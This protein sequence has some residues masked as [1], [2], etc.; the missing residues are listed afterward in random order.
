MNSISCLALFFLWIWPFFS[1]TEIFEMHNYTF[2]RIS[3]CF[4]RKIYRIILFFCTLFSHFRV[5]C[6]SS[7]SIQQTVDAAAETVRRSS[8]TEKCDTSRI[9]TF[10]NIQKTSTSISPKYT[11]SLSPRRTQSLQSGALPYKVYIISILIISFLI[12]YLL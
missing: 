1:A 7:S 4:S 5:L 6:N 12:T 10:D 11:S 2:S 9:Q 3:K 8:S